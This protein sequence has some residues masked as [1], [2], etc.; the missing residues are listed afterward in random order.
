MSPDKGVQEQ[1]GLGCHSACRYVFSV[2]P[3]QSPA[4][5]VTGAER[6]MLAPGCPSPGA[7]GLL[8]PCRTSL[9]VLRVDLPASTVYSTCIAA[10]GFMGD[11]MATSERLRWL[12]PLRYDL[13]GAAKLLGNRAYHAK[14]C[15][16][17]WCGVVWCGVVWCGVVWCGVVWCGAVRCGAVRC[18]AVRCGV[19]WRDGKV[20]WARARG[21]GG[22]ARCSCTCMRQQGTG[23]GRARL[24]RAAWSIR[25]PAATL[26]DLQERLKRPGPPHA[27]LV[28]PGPGRGRAVFAPA[29]HLPHQLPA[30]PRGGG[31]ARA[32]RAAPGVPTRQR[33]SSSGSWTGGGGAGVPGAVR[34]RRGGCGVHAAG[35][36]GCVALRRGV[37]S[38]G[39]RIPERD[40]DRHALP[41]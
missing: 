5:K 35:G 39:R 1:F 12:G 38:S 6:P 37:A 14:V 19:A 8:V 27:D 30:L 26:V 18:G 22:E 29:R 4:L 13:V 21:R 28:H 23:A 17:V 2:Q 34:C 31:A 40:A 16:V 25:P 10:W 33:P 36:H 32:L 20:D 24:A 11:V 9:D 7:P 3:I 15:G 41:E